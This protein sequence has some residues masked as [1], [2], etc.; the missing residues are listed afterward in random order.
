MRKQNRREVARLAGFAVAASTLVAFS[1]A[2]TAH[3]LPTPSCPTTIVACGCTIVPNANHLYVVNSN[4]TQS[5]GATNP[6]CID[7]AAPNTVLQIR[8]HATLTGNGEGGTTGVKVEKV[9]LFS[10]VSGIKRGPNP[11]PPGPIPPIPPVPAP[12]DEASIIRF[13]NGIE[14]DASNV[15]VEFFDHLNENLNAGVFLN[16]VANASVGGFCADRNGVAGVVANNTTGSRIYNFTAEKNG[17][18]GALLNDSDSN[19][20]YNFTMVQNVTDGVLLQGSSGNALTTGSSLSNGADGVRIGCNSSLSNPYDCDGASNSNH[21]NTVTATQLTPFLEPVDNCGELHQPPIAQVNGIHVEEGD[22]GN[23][24]T[25][26]LTSYAPAILPLDNTAFNLLDDNANC[27]SNTWS[28]NVFGN[29]SKVKP[30][31]AGNP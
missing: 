21:V 8:N 28:N 29:M 2:G 22:S 23:V 13:D 20:L 15:V 25:G 12:G 18:D 27:D 4:L 26:N 31:C 6:I 14:V 7:I 16:N 11:M 10:V 19:S 5:A 3:A 1:M 24:I 9:A 30:P 17:F